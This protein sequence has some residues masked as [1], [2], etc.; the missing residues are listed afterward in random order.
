MRYKHLKGNLYTYY[1]F[2]KVKSTRENIGGQIYVSDC[3]WQRFYP[4]SSKSL[5]HETFDLLAHR[6]GILD[7]LISDQAKEQVAGELCRKV[8]EAG[9][10][11]KECEPYSPFQNRAEAGIR[12]LKCVTK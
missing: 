6:E 12:E 7:V 5:S 9:V 10:Q 8:R 4:T 3:E 2:S 11:Y 1:M